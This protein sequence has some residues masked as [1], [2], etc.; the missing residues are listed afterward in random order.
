MIVTEAER[1]LELNAAAGTVIVPSFGSVV[2]FGTVGWVLN[3]STKA[4]TFVG[5]TD[6]A[7]SSRAVGG[8]AATALVLSDHMSFPPE[9]VKSE[10]IAAFNRCNWD[11]PTRRPV[12]GSQPPDGKALCDLI[13]NL[14]VYFCKVS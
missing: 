10:V 3:F 11:V 1:F 8:V 2:I 4:S 6:F 14:G 5:T 7:G 9:G 12:P 13:Y